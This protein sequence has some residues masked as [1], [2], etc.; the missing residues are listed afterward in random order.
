MLGVQNNSK[1]E[2]HLRVN[3]QNC[4]KLVVKT[5]HSPSMKNIIFEVIYRMLFS[6]DN[7]LIFEPSVINNFIQTINLFGMSVDKFRRMVKTLIC[8]HIYDDQD[9]FY[10]HMANLKIFSKKTFNET[11]KQKLEDEIQKG[12]DEFPGFDEPEQ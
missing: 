11:L 6:T 12:F 5:F 8:E 4:V 1:E 3:I 2:V 9:F 7:F 10:V